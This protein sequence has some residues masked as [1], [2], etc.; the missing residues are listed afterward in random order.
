MRPTPTDS[1]ALTGRED[2][3]AAL[4][5]FGLDASEAIDGEPVSAGH[6]LTVKQ[7]AL[8][9]GMRLRR[10]RAVADTPAFVAR[11]DQLVR[12]LRLGE[13]SLNLA[14]AIATRDDEGQGLAADRAVRLKAIGVIAGTK[15]KDVN[16]QIDNGNSGQQAL[17]PGYVIRLMPDPAAGPIQHQPKE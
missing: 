3:L 2:E 15:G 11:F 7:A 4:M 6:P 13:R 14:F 1:H 12:R 10:A 5:V 9:C 16:I 8:F 17:S